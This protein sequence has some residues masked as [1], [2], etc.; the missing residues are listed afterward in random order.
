MKILAGKFCRR[1]TGLKISLVANGQVMVVRCMDCT[2]ESKF[3]PEPNCSG[4]MRD[5]APGFQ[6][7][8][9]SICNHTTT[10][11]EKEEVEQVPLFI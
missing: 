5:L 2:H 11:V 10:Y 9:C 6:E 3:C 7:Q 1:C 4:Y 8:K